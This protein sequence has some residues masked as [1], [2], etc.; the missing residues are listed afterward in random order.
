M[1]SSKAIPKRPFLVRVGKKLRPVCNRLIARDSLVS[2]AAVLDSANFPWLKALEEASDHIIKECQQ[3]LA[4]RKALPPLRELSPDHK[5][6]APD[7]SWKSFFLYGY[8]IKVPE[9]CARAPVTAQL[10][11]GIPGLCNALFSVLDP[12]GVI[13]PHYGVTKGMLNC[14]LG[15]VIPKDNENCWIMVNGRK[16]HWQAGKAFV[17]DDTY[18]H[19]VENNTDDIRAILFI[20][21]ERPTRGLGRLVQKLFLGGVRHSAFVKDAKMNIERWNQIQAEMEKA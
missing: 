9:N 21:L 3:V 7:E 14:H 1:A 5:R 16:L 18:Q 8:G 11:A 19:T 4:G 20:Q 15:L 6:I 13:P 2:N 10:V 17:F 12:H